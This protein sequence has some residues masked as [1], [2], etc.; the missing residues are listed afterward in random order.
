MASN[1]SD[2]RLCMYNCR[3]VTRSFPEVRQLCDSHDLV[4]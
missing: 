3:S 4:L 2:L 1:H